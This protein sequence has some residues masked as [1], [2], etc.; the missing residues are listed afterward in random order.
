MAY[1]IVRYHEEHEAA[2]AELERLLWRGD[3][4]GNVA[5]LRWKYRETPL[6]EHCFLFVALDAG[7]VVGVRG[8]VAGRWEARRAEDAEPFRFVALSA[9]D[10]V[11]APELVRFVRS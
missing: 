9:A 6:R 4:A 1:E 11:I 10:L 8:L 7:R 5:H 3:V 2:V